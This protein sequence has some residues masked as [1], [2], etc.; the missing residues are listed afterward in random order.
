M[1]LRWLTGQVIVQYKGKMLK[2]CLRGCNNIACHETKRSACGHMF[3]EPLR[4]V[5]RLASHNVTEYIGQRMKR[6]YD[7]SW[8]KRF[9]HPFNHGLV[10]QGEIAGEPTADHTASAP[11]GTHTSRVSSHNSRSQFSFTVL[12]LIFKWLL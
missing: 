4:L 5:S 9:V 12:P 8:G 11:G 7:V 6:S 1:T 2:L 10:V 3:P